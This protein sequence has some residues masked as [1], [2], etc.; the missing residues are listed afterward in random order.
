[1]MFSRCLFL[2]VP[3]A[4]LLAQNPAPTA[5]PAAASEKPA[6]APDKVVITVGDTKITAA[7]LDL[8]IDAL[9]EQYHAQVRG[10]GR[11]QFGE[12]VARILVLAQEGRRRKLDQAPGFKTEVDFQVDQFLATKTF[13]E[14]NSHLKPTDADLQKYYEAHKS[15]YEEV[16]ARHIL[17]HTK[18]LS[19]SQK[20]QSEADA[21][22]KV[23]EIRK[24]IVD[25]AD[26]AAVASQESDDAGSKVKGGDLGTFK[27]GQMVPPFEQAAFTLKIGELSE[28][29][30]SQFGY[31]L[32]KVES[33]QSKPFEEVKAE[34]EK[35]IQPEIAQKALSDLEKQ[36]NVKLD[37]DFFG[38]PAK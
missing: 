29:V 3:A 19:P 9:P 23:Q 34:L 13:A 12:Q 10:A 11:A 20:E 36:A 4:C 37:P 33:R 5:P 17:I 32:I 38:P 27:H 21:L 2:L 30:K 1:M 35:R 6:V 16:H 14:M 25:G 24:K 18:P 22:A 31:H 26:F 8:I 15:D 28:P 7:Q